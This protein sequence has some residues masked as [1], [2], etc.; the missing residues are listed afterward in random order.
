MQFMFLDLRF[1]SPFLLVIEE[2]ISIRISNIRKK[3][4]DS[5]NLRLM[6]RYARAL[7]SHAWYQIALSCNRMLNEGSLLAAYEL[8][9]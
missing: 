6:S 8:A 7:W 4:L 3:T 5:I 9:E 1:F 2:M